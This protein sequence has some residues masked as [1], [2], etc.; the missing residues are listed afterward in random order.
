MIRAVRYTESPQ[1]HVQG[2]DVAVHAR[3]QLDRTP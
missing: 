2:N 1:M 3:Q